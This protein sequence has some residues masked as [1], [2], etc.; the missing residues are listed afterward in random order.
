MTSDL[1]EDGFELV[2]DHFM[3]AGSMEAE[4]V[5]PAH[6][7]HHF[8]P[9][10]RDISGPSNCSV[11]SKVLHTAAARVPD[12]QQC[13]VCQTS[14]HNLCSRKIS[15][16]PCP[17]FGELPVELSIDFPTVVGLDVQ[18]FRCAHCSE[19]IAFRNALFSE[20]R[21]CHY[22]GKYYCVK[23]MPD[24][25][26]KPLP[27]LMVH[28]WDPT[29][30]PVCALAFAMLSALWSEHCIII[31]P[32]SRLSLHAEEL[33]DFMRVRDQLRAMMSFIKT[34]RF[35]RS[36]HHDADLLGAC[37]RLHS[38]NVSMEILVRLADDKTYL[39]ELVRIRDSCSKHI[40][41]DCELCR[42]KGFYC[43]VCSSQEIVYPFDMG[44]ARCPCGSLM[45]ERC[46]NSAGRG[47]AEPECSRC[48]RRRL[49][50]Q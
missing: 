15:D 39:G 8:V 40:K 35:A 5:S 6:W 29:P 18:N 26:V 2:E 3:S 11:C 1:D 14:V 12:W 16:K 48:M 44:L 32:R 23:C 4:W 50:A 41:T 43:T 37:S 27:A 9:K 47:D 34:C 33:G 13:I 36:S 31:P 38:T 21:Q 10:A 24:N 49:Q 20:A 22:M 45:H 46:C 42:L 7:C 17:G 25:L 30:R 28:N 19:N